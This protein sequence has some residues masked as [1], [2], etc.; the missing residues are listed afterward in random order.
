[1]MTHT[2]RGKT[3]L[4]AKR[5]AY[6][7]LGTDAVIVTTR[8]VPRT[9]IAGFLGGDEVEVSAMTG[10]TEAATSAKSSYPRETKTPPG[11]FNAEVYKTEPPKA[12]LDE[13]VGLRS[14][15]RS[16]L[17]AMKGVLAKTSSN[18][19]VLAEVSALRSMLED[20]AFGGAGSERQNRD[21]HSHRWNRRRCGDDHRRRRT[22]RRRGRDE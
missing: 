8:N 1:M 9:G 13:L 5:T 22:S 14:Q 17:R 16:E 4:D 19:E 18:E 2:F 3:L 11:P 15:V 7:E 21:R 10:A 6:R 20:L 12:Q